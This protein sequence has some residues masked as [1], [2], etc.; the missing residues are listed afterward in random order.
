MFNAVFYQNYVY[1]DNCY[2][3]NVTWYQ[4]TFNYQRTLACFLSQHS[5]GHPCSLC[6]SIYLFL[7]AKV[8]K[9]GG[10]AR[11]QAE[12]GGGSAG[13]KGR[14][15]VTNPISF[16]RYPASRL[17]N[18]KNSGPR[19]TR[20][21]VCASLWYQFIHFYVIF[22]NLLFDMN[23]F[24]LLLVKEWQVVSNSG[25]LYSL[26]TLTSPDSSF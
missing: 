22:I 14:C 18:L 19:D 2:N 24:L 23:I 11:S 1:Y 20:G 10:S 16:E 12:L 26:T 4:W 7:W 21:K 3:Y 13:L 9:G 8:C 5:R 25:L 17:N 6:G 15:R